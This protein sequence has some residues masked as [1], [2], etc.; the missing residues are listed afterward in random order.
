MDGNGYNDI[1]TL[2]YDFYNPP[3]DT[4][5]V[6]ILFNDGNG[7]FVEDPITSIKDVD[8]LLNNFTLFQN[9]PNPFNPTTKI[10][11]QIKTSNHVKLVVYD[12]LGRRVETLVNENKTPGIFEIEFNGTELSSGVYYYCLTSE[13][14]NKRMKMILVK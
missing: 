2:N 6:H 9:Y 5:T 10:K 8:K 1:L 14:Y 7:N 12:V 3:P 4:G 11:Y 13:G